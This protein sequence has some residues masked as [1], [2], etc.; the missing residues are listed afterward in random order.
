MYTLSL[1]KDPYVYE[2]ANLCKPRTNIVNYEG[3]IVKVFWAGK[4][5][6]YGRAG[7]FMKNDAAFLFLVQHIE[8]FFP[9]D[10]I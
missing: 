1:N 2:M 5:F 9:F 6:L 10:G 3:D 4:Q 7:C 8:N